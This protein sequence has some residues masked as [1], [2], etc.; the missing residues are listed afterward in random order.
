MTIRTKFAVLILLLT[1]TLAH[2]DEM[3]TMGVIDFIVDWPGLKGQR[4][5]VHGGY[6]VQ[7]TNDE[8]FLRRDSNLI[9][10]FPPWA[11]R[12]FLRYIL[13]N[14]SEIHENEACALDVIGDVNPTPLGGTPEL[15]A[16]NFRRP[17][18]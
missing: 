18:N 16:V 8:A 12:E 15:T 10:L 17:M 6:V 7:A 11:D 2:A 4:V 14:C 3:K 9:A 1:G 13:T 5:I